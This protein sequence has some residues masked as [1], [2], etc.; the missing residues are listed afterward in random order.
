MFA[1]A[2]RPRLKL[3]SWAC[4]REVSTARVVCCKSPNTTHGSG[5]K[6]QI[7]PTESAWMAAFGIPPTAVGGLFRSSLL[8]A[9]TRQRSEEVNWQ[10][11]SESS[12]NFRWW[13]FDLVSTAHRRDLSIT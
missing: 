13:D 5:W 10:V 2:P 8:A 4:N 1:I 3:A 6:F 11:G 12:T 9:K 7:Q